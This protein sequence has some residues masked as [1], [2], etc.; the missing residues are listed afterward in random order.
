MLNPDGVRIWRPRQLFIGS[1]LRDYTEIDG[2][3]EVDSTP[4]SQPT[5]VRAGGGAQ[6]C[7]AQ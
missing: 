3:K 7:A 5:E 4:A 1:S 6:F 2:R